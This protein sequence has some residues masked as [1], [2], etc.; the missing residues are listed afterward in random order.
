[1]EEANYV[2]DEAQSRHR[3][4]VPAGI[5]AIHLPTYS[6]VAVFSAPR[7]SAI[8]RFSEPDAEGQVAFIESYLKAGDAVTGHSLRVIKL[9]DRTEIELFHRPFDAL[10]SG[11]TGQSL[12]LAPVGGRVALVG[13]LAA[14]KQGNRSFD[15][16]PLEIWDIKKGT[17][18][19]TGIIAVDKGLSWFPD[20]KRLAYVELI[21]KD[22][23]IHIPSDSDDVEV[24][25][26]KWDKVPAVQV[27]ETDTGK[28]T[29]IHVG[30]YP[31]VSANSQT[32]LVRDLNNGYTLVDVAT[33]RSKPVQLP[34]DWQGPIALLDGNLILYRGLPTEGAAPRYVLRGSMGTNRWVPMGSVKLADLYTGKFQTIVPY[35]CYDARVRFGS[36]SPQGQ[37][38]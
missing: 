22:E 11:I 5:I 28:K 18:L 24:D 27:L 36:G 30:F 9:M 21:S 38:Q 33:R 7:A 12:A 19:E 35:V 23:V 15:V 16:G 32:V 26:L 2:M 37:E 20:G 17:G 29:F 6:K 8:H 31:K 3:H 13:K 10:W 14:V 34:G 25:F 4:S 1:M